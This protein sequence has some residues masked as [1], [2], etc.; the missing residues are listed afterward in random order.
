[1]RRLLVLLSVLTFICSLLLVTGCDNKKTEDPA[2]KNDAAVEE[3]KGEEID[4][5]EPAPL[6]EGTPPY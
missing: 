3:S 5:N 6:P 4:H 2:V 1:M